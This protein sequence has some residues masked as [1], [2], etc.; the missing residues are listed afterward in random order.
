MPLWDFAGGPLVRNLPANAGD[1]GLVRGPGRF[2][3]LQGNQVRV[4]SLLSPHTLEPV[5]TTGEATAV[6]SLSTETRA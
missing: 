5:L 2:H 6:R 1:M 4:P 3:I